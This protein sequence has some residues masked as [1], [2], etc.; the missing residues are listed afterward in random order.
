MHSPNRPSTPSAV[1]Y[2]L[3]VFVILAITYPPGSNYRYGLLTK[4][5]VTVAYAEMAICVS[6][7]GILV[8]LF[9]NWAIRRNAYL[10]ATV[11]FLATGLLLATSG[12]FMF[13]APPTVKGY[14]F[15]GNILTLFFR[16]YMGLKFAWVTA[17]L[18]ALLLA[19][20]ILAKA[21]YAKPQKTTP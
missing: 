13:R 9:L 12:I 21:K 7:L 14:P 16:D 11:G 5:Q 6:L 3:G 2:L 20:M 1:M 19:V 8:W 15:L 18:C 4:T 10:G 17:P